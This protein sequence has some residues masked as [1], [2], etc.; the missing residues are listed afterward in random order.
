ML[1]STSVISSLSCR[2]WEACRGMRGG[3]RISFSGNFM[4]L[5]RDEESGGDAENKSSWRRD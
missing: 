4:W 2:M 3:I 5:V 1:T